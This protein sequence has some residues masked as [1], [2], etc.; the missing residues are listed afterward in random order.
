LTAI[1]NGHPVR[2]ACRAAGYARRCVYRWRGQDPA[3]ADAWATAM[4][5][6]GDLLE[7]EADRRGRDGVDVPVFHKGEACGVKRKYADGLLLARLKAIR[8]EKYRDQVMLAKPDT[9]PVAVQLRDFALE[10]LTQRLLRGETVEISE[11][12]Q[13]LRHL[14]HPA[15]TESR[16]QEP[17]STPVPRV[18]LPSAVRDAYAAPA[19]GSSM[20]ISRSLR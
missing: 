15:E 14:L 19:R 9:Q 4:Q 16:T 17:P 7:E 2:V 18:P 5:M 13:R 11:I 1:E 3:F 12:P 20:P 10:Q 8:P 6:A